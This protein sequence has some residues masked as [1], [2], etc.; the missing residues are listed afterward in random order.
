MRCWMSAERLTEKPRSLQPI[1]PRQLHRLRNS[2]TRA[3]EHLAFSA[4]RTQL[5]RRCVERQSI[6][7]MRDA[8]RFGEAAGPGAKQLR[9]GGAAAPVH[10]GEA[11]GRLQRA[12][13]HRAR[14]A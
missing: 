5:E 1:A 2:D 7:R 13:Q 4:A 11:H 10:C 14:R 12:D 9:I 3:Y 8:E 6:V